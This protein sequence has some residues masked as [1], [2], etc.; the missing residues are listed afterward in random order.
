MAMNKP[1][2]D[3][4]RTAIANAETGN[5]LDASVT[6]VCWDC[7]LLKDGV[8]AGGGSG[9]TAGEA[10]GLAWLSVMDPD[11]LTDARIKEECSPI[12]LEI[13]EYWEFRLT[14]PAAVDAN[15]AA[16]DNR[17]YLPYG[18]AEFR[19]VVR[20]AIRR[21][22]GAVGLAAQVLRVAD[23]AG[24]YGVTI[25]EVVEALADAGPQP[26]GHGTDPEGI[27]DILLRDWR[28]PLTFAQTAI[29]HELS[30]Q[31]ARIIEQSHEETDA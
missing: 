10:M 9:H 7:V 15:G 22:P 12:P 3:D 5:W 13:P 24:E 19:R 23:D 6:P 30:D 21:N 8:Q 11:A 1:T 27:A 2:A 29:R 16:I 20:E 26:P 18:P 14:A 31:V 4:I 25:P 17:P 28:I